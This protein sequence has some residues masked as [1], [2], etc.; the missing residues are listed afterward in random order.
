MA[1]IIYR[2]TIQVHVDKSD[3]DDAKVSADL[4]WQKFEK[5]HKGSFVDG[6]MLD[7]M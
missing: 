2:R 1:T 5:Q 3:E 4:K 6:S 7:E